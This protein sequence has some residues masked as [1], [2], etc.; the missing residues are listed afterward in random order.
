MARPWNF[1]AG[2]SALPE[3]VL[4]QAAAEMLDWHGSGM[5]V[6]EMSHRGKHFV[7][8]CDE[9][10][11][12]LR[13]LLGLSPDYAVMFMQ[14]GGSGENA[15]VPMNLMGRR[16]TPAADFVVTGHW[17]S[18]SHKEAGR[19]GDAQVAATSGQ[20]TQL[21]GREQAP[22]TWVPPVDTWKVR[23]ESAYLHLCSNETIGGVEFL[24]W[25]DTAAL[26]APDV[27]LVVDASSHF[28]S[29]PM[30]VS[31]C[32]MMYAGAQKNAGPAGVTMAICRR[33]LIGHAL[34]ICPS[35]FDYA[36]VAAEHSRYNTPPTF[37]IYIAGLVFK[38]VKANGGVA[39]MEAANKAK[40]ELL[41]GY[42][43]ST[44]FYRNPI[45]AP[46]RSRMNVPFV[47]RDESLND[48]FLQGADA[49]GLTQL[50]GHKSVGGMRASI[51]NAVPLAAVAALVEY[52]KEFERRYG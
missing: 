9:A 11:S 44:S 13:D 16:G 38:W 31:R 27:P 26:G 20:A 22:Y 23:K 40:A 14:G 8:I 30:D 37:A 50:K 25:P 1:S 19:Y 52:L 43:D 32:G 29:R 15:I 28:L 18:R 17:S 46:V 6:M 34:P 51:Y 49:A 41:Y 12:D 5:S 47:L 36:N 42:L 48:A 33:D 7:Q 2:P 45:H 21:D 10:E 35:A 39:G 24:D 3:V 4:Q